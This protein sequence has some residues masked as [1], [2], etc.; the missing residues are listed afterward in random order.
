MN[1]SRQAIRDASREGNYGRVIQ[2]ARRELRV[3]QWQLGEACGI[4]QSAV[5]RFE[6]RT[7]GPYNMNILA[8]AAAYLGLPPRLVGLADTT[9]ATAAQTDGRDPVERRQFL[10][11]VAT[12]AATA[13]APAL[14]AVAAPEQTED[15]GQ[16][17]TLGVATKAFR[18]MD[19][20]TPSRQLCEMVLA[21]LR[22]VQS[23]AAET[24]DEAH[25][26]RLSAV[27]SEA[28]SLAGWLSWD[29]GDPG[30]ARTWY[31][32]AIKA[33]RRSGHRLLTAYQIGSLAQMEADAG[34]AAQA[35]N[36]VGSARRQL[37]TSPIAIADAW[38]STVEALAYAAAGDHRSCDRALAHSRSAVSQL[39]GGEPP[40]WPWVFTF[41]EAKVEACRVTCGARLGLP[42]WVFG[43]QSAVAVAT[44]SAHTKQR[45][46][47]QLDLA[48]G[49]VA[50]G[51]LEAGYLLATQAV[52][53]GLRYRSG[54]VVDRARLFRRSY[55]SRTPPRVVR[56]FDEKL[57]GA[58]L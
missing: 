12:V 32:S 55:S 33:A 57:H 26:V 15:T 31:G 58:Y 11:G 53:T 7:A 37:E 40:P 1:W 19:G 6:G 29:M 13:A 22:F 54:R 17:A 35:L 14:A 34:N 43:S 39:T 38:L 45:A 44:S 4:T 3:T 18:R 9:A 56:E 23:V 30:S 41:D 2:L 21:H 25:R 42:H 5:S 24:T 46:L 36:L 10:I 20:A 48:A 16:A 28:A 50:G 27:G 49:H 52:E 8:S 47:L 51:R